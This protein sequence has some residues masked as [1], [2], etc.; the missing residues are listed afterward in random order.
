MSTAT[1]QPQTFLFHREVRGEP[2]FYPIT[3]A[4]EKHVPFHVFANPGTLKVTTPDGRIVWSLLAETIAKQQSTLSAF[5]RIKATTERQ[6]ATEGGA[7]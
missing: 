5:D 2:F 3:L 6:V 4:D 1:Q 7:L